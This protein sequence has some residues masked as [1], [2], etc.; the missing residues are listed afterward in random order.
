[1]SYIIL[2]FYI[3]LIFLSIH[4]LN[5]GINYHL[6]KVLFVIFLLKALKNLQG[7][8]LGG[9]SL[10]LNISKTSKNKNENL[11]G[12]KRNIIAEL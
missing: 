12:N 2:K 4:F 10:K 9:H 7:R 5:K 3:S 11:L 1:M 8:L 6:Q